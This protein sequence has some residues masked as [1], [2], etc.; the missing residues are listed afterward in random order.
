VNDHLD[1]ATSCGGSCSNSDRAVTSSSVRH[2]FA[3]RA[4]WNDVTAGPGCDLES[5]VRYIPG[6]GYLNSFAN[7]RAHS[8]V[9]N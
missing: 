1:H 8:A 9:L 2:S 7:I 4:V 6:N 5:A 3:A